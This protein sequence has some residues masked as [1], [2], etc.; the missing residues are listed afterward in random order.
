MSRLK[1]KRVLITQANDYMGPIT[2]K[3]FSKEGAVVF[4]DNSDLTKNGVCEEAISKVG[5]IDILVANLS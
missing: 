5:V 2:A 4:C 1:D 3:V